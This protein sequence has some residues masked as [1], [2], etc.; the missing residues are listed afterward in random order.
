MKG[1]A[2][3]VL[4]L[5]VLALLGLLGMHTLTA[6][7]LGS[8]DQDGLGSTGF[9]HVFKDGLAKGGWIYIIPTALIV[10]T[11]VYLKRSKER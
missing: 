10:T 4:V 5:S 11:T 7:F 1:I 9:W 8:W 3:A 6:L 2:I